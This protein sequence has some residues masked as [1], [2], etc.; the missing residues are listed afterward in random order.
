MFKKMSLR[1]KLLSIGLTLTIVPLAIVGG[2]VFAQN[3]KVQELAIKES[4]ALAMREVD[5]TTAGI[6]DMC[7]AQNEMFQKLVENGLVVAQKLVSEGGGVT[8]SAT[9]TLSWNASNQQTEEVVSTKLPQIVIGQQPLVPNTDPATPSPLVDEV[10]RLTGSVCT[11][12]QRMNEQGD[13]LCVCTS[14]KG[15]DGKR[16]LSTFM[17]R[18]MPDGSVNPVVA[19]LLEGKPYCGRAHIVNAWYTAGYTPLFDASGGVIGAIFVGV[20]QESAVGL[21]KAIMA[22]KI[23]K[24]GYVYVLNA[25]GDSRG[26]YVISKD[27]KRDGENIWE[28]KDA[29]GG[30]VI[31]EICQKALN[32]QS[33]EMAEHRYAWKNEG[34][35]T[36]RDKIVHLMYFEPWDWVIGGGSY[37]DEIYESARAIEAVTL[38]GYWVMGLVGAGT[39]LATILIWFFVAAG[40]ASRIF[41][42]VD[43]LTGA[44]RQVS[45][46]AAQIAQSSEIMAE[47][48]TEQASSLEETSASLQEMSS[49]THHNADNARQ[50][51]TMAVDAEGAATQGRDAM[52]RMVAAIARIQTSSEETAKIL[53][54]IDEIAF[55]TNLLALNAAVEAARAGEAGKGFAVVAEEVRNLAQRSAEAAKNTAI[56]IDEARKNSSEGVDACGE[57]SDVLER[58]AKSIKQVTEFVSEVSSASSEQAQGIEQINHAVSQMD[59]ITQ[60]GA[61]NS[62]EAASA[63]E[64][65]SAQA[66]D[67]ERMVKDLLVLVAGGKVRQLG[68]SIPASTGSALP[69]K[70]RQGLLSETQ[71]RSSVPALRSANRV[72]KREEVVALTDED[73]R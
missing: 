63:S 41:A 50:A 32:L 36:A 40:L 46:A 52:T 69:K 71:R 37:V 11:I 20:P 54:S 51:N 17:P 10:T 34:D 48:A 45:S 53:K 39:V 14:V 4:Q 21:R 70:P 72:I 18:T 58:I 16:A 56:L 25:K 22:A 38:R 8:L 31:Q 9:E 60:G 6:Y 61:A 47:G 12:F 15:L 68:H 65:L 30:D 24:T 28:M 23:G 62:E 29:D 73:L 5:K 13:M 49:M 57:V 35:A 64:E 2:V 55:Q 3:S 66:A 42:I 44:S 59:K 67:L 1:A 26:T 27:G 43:Q 33:G 19:T 7:S